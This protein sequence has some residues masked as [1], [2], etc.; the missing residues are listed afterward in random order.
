MIEERLRAPDREG[1]DDDGAAALHRS[2]DDL[3]QGLFRIGPVVP[4]IAIGRLDD[5]VVGVADSSR[6]DHHRIVVAAE[7]A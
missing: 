7:I 2:E 3:R 6:C 5:Q 4:A 1:G